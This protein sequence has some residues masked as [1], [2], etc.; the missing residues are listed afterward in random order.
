MLRP[1]GV[2]EGVQQFRVQE[3]VLCSIC[4]FEAWSSDQTMLADKFC[5]RQCRIKW[6]INEAVALLHTDWL[7]CVKYDMHC[8]W[9]LHCWQG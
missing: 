2:M 7:H 1:C 3:Q 8:Q 5:C 9:K 6:C 4:C